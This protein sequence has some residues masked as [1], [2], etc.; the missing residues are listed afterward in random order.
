[1]F[2]A[3]VKPG[4][5]IEKQLYALMFFVHC[6]TYSVEYKVVFWVQTCFLSWGR[7]GTNVK[8][9][10][11]GS[12]GC[13]RLICRGM[14]ITLQLK[15]NKPCLPFKQTHLYSCKQSTKTYL[16]VKKPKYGLT[17]GIKVLKVLVL[18]CSFS[19]SLYWI[20]SFIFFH[21]V[22]LLG[23]K[24]LTTRSNLADYTCK[25]NQRLMKDYKHP[26]TQLKF[27]NLITSA[28]RDVKDS[29]RSVMYQ[30]YYFLTRL[31]MQSL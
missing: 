25:L 11:G 4:E 21:G 23:K 13:E 18:N 9:G 17:D 14:L 12:G 22:W 19:P 30:S 16:Q 6:S 27:Y 1:M 29:R 7:Q 24:L 20:L 8:R 31:G 28:E 10:V 2:H 15:C 5:S 26:N 3:G